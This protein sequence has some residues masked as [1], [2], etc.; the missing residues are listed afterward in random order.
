MI[1]LR[2]TLNVPMKNQ[3]NVVCGHERSRGV[4]YHGPVTDTRARAIN[5]LRV[6][7]PCGWCSQVRPRP[8]PGAL[9]LPAVASA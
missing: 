1:V 9:A 5:G 4:C 6:Y 7:A 8:R 2:S 3:T